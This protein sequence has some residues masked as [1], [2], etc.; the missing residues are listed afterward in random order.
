MYFLHYT[1]CI[2]SKN[3]MLREFLAADEGR[4]TAPCPKGQ[5]TSGQYDQQDLRSLLFPQSQLRVYSMHSFG[6][7]RYG[8]L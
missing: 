5:P 4:G 3:I 6:R 2:E 7:W 1:P 8:H